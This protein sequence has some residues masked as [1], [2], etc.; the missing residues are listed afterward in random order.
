MHSIM[1]NQQLLDQFLPLHLA[2]QRRLPGKMRKVSQL[3]QESCAK[4]Q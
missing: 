4:W 1:W 2:V 3:W